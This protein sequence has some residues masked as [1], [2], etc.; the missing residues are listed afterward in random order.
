[1]VMV[2]LFLVSLVLVLGL[3]VHWWLESYRHNRC[4][5]ALRIRIHVNGIRGKST[6]SRI[7]AGL[8][9][10]AGVRTVAKTTGSAAV[11][12]TPH[13]IDNPI[14]RRGAATILEQLDVVQYA[15]ACDAEAIVVECMALRP[16]YQAISE[17]RMVRSTIG[18]ITNVREDHQDV[19]GQTLPE[20][21][22]SLL[23]TCP[24]NGVLVT[25]EQEPHLQEILQEEAE[26]RRSQFVV[27]E[28]DWVTDEDIARFGYVAF[29]DNVAIGLAIARLLGIPRDVAMAG[30][31]KAAPDPGVLCIQHLVIGEKRVT[32]ANLFAVNDRESTLQ[33][34]E[35]VLR[36]CTAE[37]TTVGIL[38][39]RPD[40]ED[41]ALQFA[42]IASCDLAFDWLVTFG[43]YENVVAERLIANGYAAERILQLGE[44]HNPTVD[45]I[46]EQVVHAMPSAH[47]LLVGLVNIHTT[48]AELLL[49][50]LEDVAADARD[51]PAPL[52]RIA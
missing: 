12:I 14:H 26:R 40:R 52:E 33:G 50:Y 24:R 32:W 39:N 34:M 37:T 1:M 45:E 51:C 27:A 11:I 10:E 36:Y 21:A 3:L 7:V 5:T 29:K 46:I 22:C 23:N 47:V 18:V 31:V 48:Q 6:V 43:A 35:K 41:R 15:E 8:L 42:D 20:I 2:P 49:Q 28:P 25:A 44:R 9:R 30:M 16:S 4:L 13:G 38:N 19:M 17:G